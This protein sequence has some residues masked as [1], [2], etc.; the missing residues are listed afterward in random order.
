MKISP[1]TFYII[2]HGETEYNA[3][4]L[5]QGHHDSPLTD[6]GEQQIRELAQQLAEIHFD[7][8]FS[9]DLMRA[10]RTA[11]ILAIE[12]KLVVNTTQLLR[13]RNFGSYEGKKWEIFQEE[14][15]Q[16][17]SR[18]ETLSKAEQWKFKYA[19]DIESDEEVVTRL[20][21]FIRE[22]AV[23]YEGKNILV[24]AHGGVLRTLLKHLGYSVAPGKGTI[25]NA[26]YVK[27]LSDGADF[28]IKEMGG[29]KLVD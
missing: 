23:T 21:T 16:L 29:V 5:L 15:K 3:K 24:V 7:H 6:R 4:G 11:E 25:S 1:T 20:L 8:V 18:F 26:A 13:E 9:S 19:S 17:I 10:Q 28:E 27:I 2:R 14:N 22:T 12:K